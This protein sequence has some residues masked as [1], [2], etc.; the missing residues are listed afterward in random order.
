MWPLRRDLPDKLCEVMGYRRRM[1]YSILTDSKIILKKPAGYEISA[2]LIVF[3]KNRN[4][5]QHA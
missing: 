2:A 5:G 4:A 1:Q 3:G